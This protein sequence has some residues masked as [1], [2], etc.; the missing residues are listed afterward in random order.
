MSTTPEPPSVGRPDIKAP[1]SS[2]PDP[3]LLRLHAALRNLDTAIFDALRTLDVV[4]GRTPASQP[5]EGLPYRELGRLKMHLEAAT[6][7]PQE[8]QERDLSAMALEWPADDDADQGDE[9]AVH[10]S[11]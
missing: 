3:A 11:T 4:L 10:E 8:P 2:A 9:Q 5:P 6:N 7:G 1:A